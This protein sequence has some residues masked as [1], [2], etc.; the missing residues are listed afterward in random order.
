MPK[1]L[2]ALQGTGN[3]HVARALEII[4]ILEKYGEVDILLSGDQSQVQLPFEVKYKMKGLTFLYSK[5]GAVSFKKTLFKNNL[6]KLLKDIWR[7]P[8]LSYDYVIN[9]F[10]FSSAWACRLRGKA[11]YGLGHQAAFL[12]KNVPRPAKKSWLGEFILKYYAPCTK[13][14]GFHFFQYAPNIYPAVIRKELRATKPLNYG[15]YTVYLPAYSKKNIADYLAKLP[16]QEWHI[17]HKEIKNAYRKKN[18]HFYPIS[19][20]GFTQSLCSCAGLLTSAGFESP[21]EA[22]FLNKKLFVVPIVRQYEQSCNAA[23]LRKLGVPTAVKLNA[24]TLSALKQWTQEKAAQ[25]SHFPDVTDAIIAN[26]I[27]AFENKLNLAG[28]KC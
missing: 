21:A 12:S 14:I 5:D 3:G 28:V 24:K 2:Y 16:D 8:V 18:L 6:F 13:A 11:C 23:A 19:S 22:L 27:F 7:L 17:F 9:D 1:I 26:E 20:N 4:P 10:E 25:Q 15:H